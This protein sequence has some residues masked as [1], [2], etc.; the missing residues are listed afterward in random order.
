MCV[1]V[2][3]LS[4]PHNLQFGL[5]FSFGANF[6]PPSHSNNCVLSSTFVFQ[7][8]SFQTLSFEMLIITKN[9]PAHRQH[10]E[11][12]TPL[13]HNDC[14]PQ[15]TASFNTTGQLARSVCLSFRTFPKQFTVGA[16]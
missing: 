9:I 1:R 14:E 4:W 3:G 16:L 12:I 5:N 11:I 8:S 13:H 15:S 10:H 6:T 2:P 7:G